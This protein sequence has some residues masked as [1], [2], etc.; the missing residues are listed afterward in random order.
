MSV[1]FTEAPL[2]SLP[3]GGLV[4]PE[5]Y[6][7]YAPFG[8]IFDK[9]WIFDKGGR[10]V[11]YQPDVDF[12][13]L[14]EELR[15]RH[16]RYEPTSD[17]VIDWTWEREWRIPCEILPF[18]SNEAGLIVPN[19]AWADRLLKEHSDD[20]DYQVHMY[21]QIFDQVIAEMYREDFPWRIYVLNE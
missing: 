8:V 11:I 18:N 5:N 21:S 12:N 15:W 17:K 20:Q 2:L 16:V 19:K 6:S 13:L 9:N 14:P 10:P 7:R 1:C 3:G 4:N